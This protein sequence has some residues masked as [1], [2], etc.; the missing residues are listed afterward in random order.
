MRMCSGIYVFEGIDNVG[1][2][3]IVQKLREMIAES[4]GCE[5]VVVAFPGNEPRTLG[6][7][8]YDIHHNQKDYFELP[9]NETSLQLLHIASHIDLI[10]GKLKQ[11]ISKPCIVLLDRFWWSTYVYGLAGNLDKN[12]IQAILEP[13]LI[14]W[15]DFNVR[16]VFLV[17]REN[18]ERDYE[19]EKD[20]R[21]VELYRD[22]AIK[23]TNSIIINNDGSIEE[24]VKEIYKNIVGA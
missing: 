18:R 23:T 15:K 9:L 22:L 7:L 14:H 12:M 2:S 21:I 13:E 11:L 5:C 24:T 6:S 16:K 19:E 17:E 1:K 8:V 3:T 4:L 10:Q 20:K